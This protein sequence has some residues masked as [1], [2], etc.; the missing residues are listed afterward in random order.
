MSK[1]NIIKVQQLSKHYGNHKILDNVNLEIFESDFTVIM[2]PSGAGKST[3]LQNISTMDK[4]TSG[5]VIFNQQDLTKLTDK[6]LSLFRKKDIGFI[7]QSFNLIEHLSVLENVCLPG[8]LLKAESKQ[9]VIQRAKQLLTGLGLDGH[10]G[11]AITHL[12]GG[13]KQRVAI[14]R[15]L[16]N[17][18]KIL[19]ADEPTGALDSTS[20]IEVL[21]S[22]TLNNQ[23]GQ[24]IV[25][26]THDLK[27]ALRADRILF[28]K[29][30]TI[31]G[32]RNFTSYDASQIAA[33]RTE[34]ES[35]L[36]EMGW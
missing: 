24:T 18:P 7:F 30:G 26:V 17:Q 11:Q 31:F 9:Q 12:S 35:W 13:Q 27:A 29:D 6:A 25:M 14:A 10:M 23:N 15:S 19:F 32:D 21:D 20:G 16:I 3:L 36:Q 22:L 28:I 33:R 2:G 1:S 34:I 5:K 4:P 8:L